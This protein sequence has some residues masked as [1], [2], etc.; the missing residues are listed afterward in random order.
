[1]IINIS[2]ND[3][4][5]SLIDILTFGVSSIV[6]VVLAKSRFH[7]RSNCCSYSYNEHNL[8]ISKLNK[9]DDDLVSEIDDE[10]MAV[11]TFRTTIPPPPPKIPKIKLPLPTYVNLQSIKK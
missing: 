11:D 9:E 3:I 10:V 1:M 5:M 8:D 6:M 7:I 2:I 4:G